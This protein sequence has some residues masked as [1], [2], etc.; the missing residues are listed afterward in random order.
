[1]ADIAHILLLPPPQPLQTRLPAREQELAVNPDAQ[2]GAET[3]RA[4]RFR[5]RVY[6][7]GE[8]GETRTDLATRQA[9][10]RRPTLD[11]ERTA[12]DA[13]GERTQGRVRY[14]AGDSRPGNSSAFLAQTFAQEQLGEG[15]HNPPF[16][17]AAAAYTRTGAA[18]YAARAGASVNLSV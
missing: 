17:A 3:A 8:S 9:S 4:K 13:T 7:G 2:A 10:D 15:L 6:E 16:A 11:N 14:A 5:F 18:A 1:M 12:Q